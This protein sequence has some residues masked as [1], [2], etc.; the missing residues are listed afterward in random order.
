MNALNVTVTFVDNAYWLVVIRASPIIAN[1]VRI[2]VEA[3]EEH[4]ECHNIACQCMYAVNCNCPCY[5]YVVIE[6]DIVSN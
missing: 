6:E 1:I 4:C 5:S 3:I 2:V